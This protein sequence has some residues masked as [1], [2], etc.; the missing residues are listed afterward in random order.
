VTG[1]SPDLLISRLRAADPAGAASP[2]PLARVAAAR[3]RRTSR[4]LARV[5]GA[6]GAL[7]VAATLALALPGGRDAD[8]IAQ[9]AAALSGPEVLHTVTVTRAADGTPA[10]RAESWRAPDGDR[11]TLVYSAAGALVAEL[12]L[13]DDESASWNAA[14]DMLYLTE[15]SALDDDPLALL[16]RARAGDPGVSLRD[17]TSVRGIPVHVIALAPTTAGE[18]P[19]PERVYYVDKETFLP[20][21]IEFGETVTDVLEADLVPL[22]RARGQ[23]EMSPHPRATVR[24]FR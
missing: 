3:R 9:A 8:V 21:R 16:A 22:R 11:R 20:V 23:L 6:G 4:N 17:D 7:A 13:S 19:V 5:G 10:S 2:P 15:N 24:D 1:D 18:D 14:G 12:V